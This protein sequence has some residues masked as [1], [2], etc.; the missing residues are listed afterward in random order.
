MIDAFD[1]EE[2]P[3]VVEVE[4]PVVRDVFVDPYIIT[5]DVD[6]D[7][8]PGGY[9]PRKD[10]RFPTPLIKVVTL[11]L[12]IENQITVFPSLTGGFVIS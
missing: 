3:I 12:P 7:D 4:D 2:D 11:V 1:R 5:V 6:P 8:A 10:A 9:A